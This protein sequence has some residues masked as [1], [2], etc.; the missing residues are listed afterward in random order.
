MIINKKNLHERFTSSLEALGVYWGD[1]STG[2]NEEQWI[3]AGNDPTNFEDDSVALLPGGGA[4]GICTFG[5]NYVIKELGHGQRYG[6]QVEDNPTVTDSL[7]DGAGGHDFAV[8]EGR[9]IVDPWYALTQSDAQGVY[10]LQ[11]S[12]DREAIESIYGNPACW[13]WFD[14]VNEETIAMTDEKLPKEM[15]VTY[16]VIRKHEHE[17]LGL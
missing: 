13:E 12:K 15:L 4:F 5:A 14:A 8:I 7:I 2:M 11:S 17:G 10:D 6:F 3:E 9:Y 16:P 1:D